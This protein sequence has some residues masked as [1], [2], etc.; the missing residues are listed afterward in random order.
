MSLAEL[1]LTQP[2][3]LDEM[4]R[5][6]DLE[7]E[8]Q[9]L[10]LQ[11]EHRARKAEATSQQ[12]QQQQQQHEQQWEPQ[13]DKQQQEHSSGLSP[14]PVAQQLLKRPG[15]SGSAGSAGSGG[16]SSTGSGSRPRRRGP[17]A[18]IEESR[19]MGLFDEGWTSTFSIPRVKTAMTT[20]TSATSATERERGQETEDGAPAMSPSSSPG[21]PPRPPSS[22]SSRTKEASTEQEQ[23]PVSSH[24]S[25]A[26]VVLALDRTTGFEVE[27]ELAAME[28]ELEASLQKYRDQVQSSKANAGADSN[29]VPAVGALSVEAEGLEGLD[30]LSALKAEANEMEDVFPDWTPEVQAQYRSSKEHNHHLVRPRSAGAT[31]FLSRREESERGRRLE[32]MPPEVVE[33]GRELEELEVR[34]KAVQSRQEAHLPMPSY[35]QTSRDATA[36]T[37][38]EAEEAIEKLR[39]QSQYLK[40]LL[41]Q[42]GGAGKGKVELL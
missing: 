37:K 13:Q 2:D 35:S 12:Q 10:R 21:R 15:S 7:E 20:A 11:R 4:L 39:E 29:E 27:D 34:L 3:D 9:K 8:L 42:S 36:T 14:L 25:L 1:I 5:D 32:Q 6:T 17:S 33:M 40:N 23:R 30:E 26:D 19:A 38:S 24:R 16:G 41:L 28:K 22:A 31:S 18:A